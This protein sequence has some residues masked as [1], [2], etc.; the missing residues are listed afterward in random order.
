MYPH[1]QKTV[2]RKKIVFDP[3]NQSYPFMIKTKQNSQDITLVVEQ[4]PTAVKVHIT[5]LSRKRLD[6][7]ATPMCVLQSWT[8]RDVSKKHYTFL[9]L[10][11]VFGNTNMIGKMCLYNVTSTART[12]I[13]GWAV[14]C[15]PLSSVSRIATGSST[16]QKLYQINFEKCK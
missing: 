10:S 3:V 12:P 13:A 4:S 9:A 8:I 11:E 2:L 5:P 14:K 6:I 16:S 1:Q 15:T 7:L